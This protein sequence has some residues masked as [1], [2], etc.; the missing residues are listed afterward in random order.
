MN[1]GDYKR[2][3][4]FEKRME[5]LESH[6]F[7]DTLTLLEILS[8]L[9]FFGSLKMEKCNYAKNGQCALFILQMDAKRKIPIASDCK[10]SG[11]EC[12]TNHLH[13]NLSNV[14]CAFCSA[15]ICEK[16]LHE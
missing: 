7:E 14:T 5:Q 2:L 13:L 3:E 16:S 4:D 6:E 1:I 8:N 10:I 11:C 9:T 12:K 15:G